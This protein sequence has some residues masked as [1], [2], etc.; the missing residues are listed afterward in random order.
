MVKNRINKAV[1]ENSLIYRY[2]YLT[3]LITFD[4]QHSAFCLYLGVKVILTR[5]S[6][7]WSHQIDLKCANSIRTRQD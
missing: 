6:P 1:M 4:V 2:V 7:A 3:G 5:P